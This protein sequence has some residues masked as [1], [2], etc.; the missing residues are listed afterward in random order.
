VKRR[1]ASVLAATYDRPIDR[2]ADSALRLLE[3]HLWPG[4][5]R[6]LEHVVER[7]VILARCE[8]IRAEDLPNSVRR[9]AL[10]WPEEE[11]VREQ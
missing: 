5:V 6:E 2:I 9:P 3:Q 4:N 10:R 8:H 7:S 1:R 11:Q